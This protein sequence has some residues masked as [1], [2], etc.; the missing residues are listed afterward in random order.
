VDSD[1]TFCSEAQFVH[2]NSENFGK[3]PQN[4]VM[5]KR[6]LHIP[7]KKQLLAMSTKGAS[8]GL[9]KNGAEHEPNKRSVLK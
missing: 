2:E 4:G 6:V 8:R 5:V 3:L 7:K 9:P 1:S